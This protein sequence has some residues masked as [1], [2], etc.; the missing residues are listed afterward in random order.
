MRKTPTD[1]KPGNS[2]LTWSWPLAS[3][4]SPLKSTGARPH[5]DRTRPGEGT[6]TSTGTY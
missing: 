3:T 1:K 2:W 5:P 6:F 4:R